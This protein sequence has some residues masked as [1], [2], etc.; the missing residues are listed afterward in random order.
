MSENVVHLAAEFPNDNPALHAGVSWVCLTPLARPSPIFYTREPVAAPAA[1]EAVDA[2][3]ALASA[4]VVTSEAP[5][6]E[7]APF[8]M[9]E[10]L[11][12]AA[13]APV[14]EPTPALAPVVTSEAPAPIVAPAPAPEPFV[15]SEALVEA[16]LMPAPE[17]FVTSE[18]L[19]EAA[20]EPA[21]EAL[22][23]AAP[24]PEAPE[25]LEEILVEDLEP[26]EA[27]EVEGLVP[28]FES[29]APPTIPVETN[30]SEL[31]P[32]SD[33]PFTALVCTLADVAIG[34]GSPLVASMLPGLL[35]DGRL[36]EQMESVAGIWDGHTLDPSFASTVAA[37]RAILRGTSEDF[38]DCGMLDE[39]A[40]ELLA[41]LLDAQ[42]T[43]PHLRQELRARGVAA[44]GLAA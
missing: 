1:N 24:P 3:P 32:A 27:A 43:T 8:V 5:A 36:P 6:P 13:P 15:T 35:F 12:E 9:S 33:D 30:T 21:P 38:S 26:L 39:W 20:P 10:A 41:R 42:D 23:D 44:F 22:V 31:P 7:P 11:V 14:A 25:P 40:S 16:A 34:A 29:I 4:P 18:A 19:V 17:P 37:W 2:A 28:V